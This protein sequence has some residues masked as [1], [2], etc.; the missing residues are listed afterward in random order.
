MLLPAYAQLTEAEKLLR[1][2]TTD[3]LAGWKKGGMVSINFAQNSFKNW[4]AGGQ[5]S[6]ALNTLLNVFANY[7]KNNMTWDNSLDIGYGFQRQGKDA[8]AMKTDDKIDL[9]SKLGKV[10]YKNWYYSGLLNFKTQ[11]APG[12]NYPNDSVKISNFL[13]PAYL[14]TALGM[15]Y[16]PN[17]NFNMFIAPLTSRVTF[18][19]NQDLA[20]AGAYGVDKAEIGANGK[21][22]KDGK[23]YRS[24][25]GGYLRILYKKDLMENVSL[26]T[27][28]D[29]FSNYLKNPQNIDIYWEMLIAMKI[30]KYMTAT[31]TTNLIYDDDIKIAYDEKNPLKF[32][33]KA[34]FK[35][36]LC[37]G[38]SYKF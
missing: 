24:E 3:T 30:N 25:F 19:N 35:E 9:T 27:K 12:Y 37:I 5:N 26:T 31:I 32:G 4:A 36:V 16:K 15:D 17:D 6:I 2:K 22:S 34:Q 18:V 1:A 7:H 14:V 33:P 20:N 38:F 29:A 10:A 23:K 28:V 8:A 21:I 11:M 13:A